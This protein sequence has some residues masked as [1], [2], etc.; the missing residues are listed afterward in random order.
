LSE[1]AL[2][3]GSALIAVILLLAGC[4]LQAAKQD[5]LEQLLNLI[6]QRLALAD[7]VARSKWNS[8]AAVEDLARERE[9]VEAIGKQAPDYGLEPAAAS[10]FFQAQIEASKI[11]QHERLG[12]WRAAALPPFENAPDLQRDIRPQL[13]RLTSELLSALA[14]ATP[15]LRAP[16]AHARLAARAG[17]AAHAA[18]LAPLLKTAKGN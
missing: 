7:A 17:D 12:K 10:A 8:G 4:A 16:D 15:A 5:P 18:A 9:I 13:D 1:R 3:D 11:A 2:R 6:D 14:Q